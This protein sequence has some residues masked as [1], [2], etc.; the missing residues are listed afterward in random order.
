MKILKE[1]LLMAIQDIDLIFSEEARKNNI[2]AG[3]TAVVVLIFDN[4]LLVANVGDSKAILCLETLIT[5]EEIRAAR[6][7]FYRQRRSQG[8]ST[9]K[10]QPGPNHF[11]VT[12]LTRDHH[13]DRDDERSRIEST[14]GGF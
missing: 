13:P 4:Q 7:K 6:E 1:S 2:L 5:K 10:F 11:S 8:D 14:L 12:E 9:K 3:S